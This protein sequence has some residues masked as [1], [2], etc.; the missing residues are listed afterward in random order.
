M[1]K[2]HKEY[3][4]QKENKPL[5]YSEY[6]YNDENKNT[7]NYK[8]YNNLFLFLSGIFIFIFRYYLFLYIS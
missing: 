6:I 8:Y 2:G 5:Y 1:K 4:G 7:E 3:K